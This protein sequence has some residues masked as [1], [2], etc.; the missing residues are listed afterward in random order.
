MLCFPAP[1]QE[2]LEL[3]NGGG[4]GKVLAYRA[5]REHAAI[6]LDGLIVK[7]RLRDL[8]TMLEFG[9]GMVVT[10][11]HIDHAR[12]EKALK[13]ESATPE[14]TEATEATEAGRSDVA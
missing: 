12:L 14:A 8:R 11:A 7:P 6:E 9:M 5:L 10:P 13:E 1:L 2:H 4:A 3:F